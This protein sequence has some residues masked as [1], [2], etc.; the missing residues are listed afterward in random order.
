MFNLLMGVKVLNLEN[1]QKGWTARTL[2]R[3]WL[4]VPVKIGN[5]THRSRARIFNPNITSWIKD[6]C[7]YDSRAVVLFERGG[8]GIDRGGS[9]CRWV[10][11]EDPGIRR[12]E[13]PFECC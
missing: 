1:N 4:T 2:I 8:A 9:S 7:I 6:R 12:I 11:R 5:H 10:C 3:F 13:V